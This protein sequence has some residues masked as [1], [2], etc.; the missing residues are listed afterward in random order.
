MRR[1]TPLKLK[2]GPIRMTIGIPVTEED[3]LTDPCAST[4]V[5]DPVEMIPKLMDVVDTRTIGCN[6]PPTGESPMDAAIV[7]PE[8][9][10]AASMGVVGKMTSPLRTAR[11]TA[12]GPFRK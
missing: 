1:S 4:G 7:S 10:V 2:P 5:A 11:K 9:P 3:T 6:G 8:V 12:I